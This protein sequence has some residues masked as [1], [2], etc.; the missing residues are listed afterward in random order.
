M[1]NFDIPNRFFFFA[2]NLVNKFDIPLKNGF[3]VLKHVFTYLFF[4]Q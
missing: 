2:G 3:Y 1:K 4:C